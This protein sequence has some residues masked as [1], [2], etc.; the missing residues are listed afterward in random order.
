MPRPS[1]PLVEAHLFWQ[2]PDV[3]SS[4]RLFDDVM[5]DWTV[6]LE[7]HRRENPRPPC[8]ATAQLLP[9]DLDYP[10]VDSETLT[11]YDGF[12]YFPFPPRLDMFKGRNEFVCCVCSEIAPH[13]TLQCDS[14]ICYVCESERGNSGHAQ[15]WAGDESDDSE[16]SVWYGEDYGE[17]DYY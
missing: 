9:G 4:L 6:R 1:A 8:R 13:R 7:K 11:M 14:T 17:E 5:C 10:V 3:A 16:L 2:E 12:I 15:D